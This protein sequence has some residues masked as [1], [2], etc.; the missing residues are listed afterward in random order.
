[1]KNRDADED[2]E[3]N[4]AE[5][6]GTRI[7]LLCGRCRYL[8]L[9]STITQPEDALIQKDSQVQSNPIQEYF[10]VNEEIWYDFTLSVKWTQNRLVS[11]ATSLDPDWNTATAQN[12][13]Y[14]SCEKKEKIK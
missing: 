9:Q 12:H 4:Q 2:D 7:W 11:D 8:R 1:M 3:W 10:T 5:K 13:F 6:N 14:K